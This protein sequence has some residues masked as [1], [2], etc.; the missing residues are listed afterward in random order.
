MKTISSVEQPL[1]ARALWHLGAGVSAIRQEQL[2]APGAGEVLVRATHTALSRGT[3]RLV[4][5]G[6][7]PV[8]EAEAMR[9]PHQAGEFTFPVKYGYCAVGE[10]VDGEAGWIG[11][12]VFALHPH[13]DLFVLPTSAVARVPADVPSSRAVLA[14]NVETALNALWD[15]AAAPGMRIAVVGAGTVGS[16]IAWLAGRLPGCEVTLVDI[17]PRRACVAA[18]LGVGWALPHEAPADCDLVFHA[19]A[20]AAG[21]N[22]AIGCAG[23]EARVVEASWY[24]NE[25]VELGLGAAF[26]SRRLTLMSSQVGRVAPAM[27]S[28][29]THARR[30]AKALSLLADPLPD[31]LLAPPVAFEQLPQCFASLLDGRDCAPC[32]IVAYPPAADLRGAPPVPMS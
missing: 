14:A 18:S 16:L 13:Q 6:R 8:S 17:A 11:Q 31:V 9:A 5:G 15:G 26:H 21:L 20:S 12:R 27:R 23:D 28:R 7:V 32:P 22:T 30:L 24:G 10:V 25:R 29:W 1:V 3:E 4:W 2:R 19:S